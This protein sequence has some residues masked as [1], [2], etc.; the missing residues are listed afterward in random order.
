V[1]LPRKLGKFVADIIRVLGYVVAQFFELRPQELFLRRHHRDRRFSSAA[2]EGASAGGARLP[3]VRPRHRG[4]M[5]CFS[6]GPL[7]HSGHSTSDRF[8]CLS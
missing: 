1:H 7:P 5:I 2:A 8:R 6:I 3:A 4:F